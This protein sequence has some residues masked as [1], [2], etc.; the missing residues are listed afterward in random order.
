MIDLV[1]NRQAD[2]I[3]AARYSNAIGKKVQAGAMLDKIDKIKAV[4]GRIELGGGLSD[5][6]IKLCT[7][8]T[9]EMLFGYSNEERIKSKTTIAS[10][11]SV[12]SCA[13][14]HPG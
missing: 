1:K 9:T 10:H 14:A 8:V 11:F 13:I 6:D 4:L 5:A 2:Y 12:P 7:P 3:K